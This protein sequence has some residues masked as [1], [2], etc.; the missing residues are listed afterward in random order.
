MNTATPFDYTDPARERLLDQI[1][2]AR[3][4]EEIQEARL[5]LRAWKLAHPDDLSIGDSGEMLYMLEDGLRTLAAEEAAMTEEERTRTRARRK[6]EQMALSP[7]SLAEAEAARE[8]LCGWLREHPDDE[9][10]RGL[11]P[12]LA[13]FQ[14]AYEVLAADDRAAERQNA[15]PELARA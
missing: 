9:A 15:A 12:T 11:F 8:A 5:A 10:M 4:L 7:W 6:V 13:L 3:T 14:E 2:G 1:L